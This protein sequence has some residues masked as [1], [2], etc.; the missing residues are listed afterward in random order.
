MFVQRRLSHEL[1]SPNSHPPC[2]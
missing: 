1:F 2:F